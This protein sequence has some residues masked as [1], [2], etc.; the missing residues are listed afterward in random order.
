MK[1]PLGVDPHEFDSI[2]DEAKSMAQIG[3]YHNHIV[4]LQGITFEVCKV[5]KQPIMVGSLT[6]YS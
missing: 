2:L 1:T 5:T 4:N 6:L 3:R